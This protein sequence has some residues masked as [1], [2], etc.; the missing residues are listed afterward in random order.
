MT[1]LPHVYI[2]CWNSYAVAMAPVT[3]GGEEKE[4]GGGWG[5][6]EEEEERLYLQTRI[7]R[8]RTGEEEEEEGGGGGG[9]ERLIK[10]RKRQ[11]DSLSRGS[12]Q[13]STQRWKRRPLPSNTAP[14]RSE[15]YPCSPGLC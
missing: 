2:V 9:G 7:A 6:A 15:V 10:D 1:R 4:G 12:E 8:R 11:V 13:A 14:P 3:P 5:G